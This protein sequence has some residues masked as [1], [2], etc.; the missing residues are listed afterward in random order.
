MD[1]DF[2]I[3]N[4]DALSQVSNDIISYNSE[5]GV[6]TRAQASAST[7]SCRMWQ[8]ILAILDNLESSGYGIKEL[9]TSGYGTDEYTALIANI[10]V[11]LDNIRGNRVL[12]SLIYLN[13]NIRG[14][15][16]T[17][18]PERMTLDLGNNYMCMYIDGVANSILHYF[19]I[20][21]TV[22]GEYYL[23]SSYGS[24]YVCVN[25]YTTLLSPDEFIR[26]IR[27]IN[28]PNT[29]EEYI[30]EFFN[31][32][33]L[34]GNT[35]RYYS[36]D[37]YEEDPSLRFAMMAPSE[38]NKKEAEVVTENIYRNRI[39]CGIMP[40]YNRL[41]GLMIHQGHMGGKKRR[42]RKSRRNHTRK[43]RNNAHSKRRRSS[44]SSKKCSH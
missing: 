42:T 18:D 26:F 15:I 37:D 5:F 19:T 17:F 32:F 8:L 21:H 7:A 16:E 27:A 10:S 29:D 11:V 20:I 43:R 40:G 30:V 44:R 1:V 12:N 28:Y 25:Q 34:A 41:I 33:F 2:L 9:I 38:G 22:D 36:R 23:N 14:S 39:R 31:K 24:D 6:K 4:K 13:Q 35:G 3:S